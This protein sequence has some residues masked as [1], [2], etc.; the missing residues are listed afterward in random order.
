M[1]HLPTFEDLKTF[2]LQTLCAHAD[3]EPD[4]P[5]LESMLRRRGQPCGME[6]LLLAGRTTRWSAIW[7]AA[8][9]RVLF[10]DP[11]LERFQESAVRGP[12]FE[13]IPVRPTTNPHLRSVWRGR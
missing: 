5:M 13:A 8:T 7:E 4:T 2:V 10:Y 9:N 11:Q 3:L 12:K 6:Y 1:I